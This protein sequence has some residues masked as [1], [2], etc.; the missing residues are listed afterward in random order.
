MHQPVCLNY[1]LDY[2][3]EYSFVA[4][5]SMEAA[6]HFEW[7]FES[8]WR[9]M[10]AIGGVILCLLCLEGPLRGR[11]GGPLGPLFNLPSFLVS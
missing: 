2:L 10:W 5:A 9:V 11:G 1:F 4:K 8:T 3:F 6:G 7:P